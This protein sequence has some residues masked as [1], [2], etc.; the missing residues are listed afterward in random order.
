MTDV[1]HES[2]TWLHHHITW[3]AFSYCRKRDKIRCFLIL[4][5]N[6]IREIWD[7]VSGGLSAFTGLGDLGACRGT[8]PSVVEGP[9][10]CIDY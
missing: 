2:I 9:N 8:F 3:N 4:L 7:W 6:S 5:K 1:G 10:R